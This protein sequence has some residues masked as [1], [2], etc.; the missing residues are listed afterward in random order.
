VVK[1]EINCDT[2]SL[3][4]IFF[5][6]AHCVEILKTN[7]QKIKKTIQ[8]YKNTQIN[9]E[10]KAKKQN[11]RNTK[12][13]KRGNTLQRRIKAQ[14]FTELLIEDLQVKKTKIKKLV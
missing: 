4:I 6:Y 8:K 12:I 2:I 1:H 14:L 11:K 9:K 13:G 3:N 7:K 5:C 10:S